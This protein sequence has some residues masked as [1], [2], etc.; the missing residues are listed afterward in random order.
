MHVGEEPSL[1]QCRAGNLSCA[2]G[3][4]HRCMSQQCR[5]WYIRAV[6]VQLKYHNQLHPCKACITASPP[7]S[8]A[9]EKLQRSPTTHISV[10]HLQSRHI[11]RIPYMMKQKMARQCLMYTQQDVLNFTGQR[12]RDDHLTTSA[13]K[14]VGP[15]VATPQMSCATLRSAPRSARLKASQIPSALSNNAAARHSRSDSCLTH[16]VVPAHPAEAATPQDL[17]HQPQPTRHASR[18]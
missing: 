8:T 3:A 15:Q 13:L 14:G 7:L 11:H 4:L 9:K 10:T 1:Q 12:S 17:P 5:H 16:S 18:C 6:S 2:R